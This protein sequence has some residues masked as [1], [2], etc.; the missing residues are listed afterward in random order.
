MKIFAHLFVGRYRYVEAFSLVKI[1]KKVWNLS[2]HLNTKQ[3]KIPPSCLV[4]CTL[5][6]L[7]GEQAI[8]E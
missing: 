3:G 1:K 5:E 8:K 6:Q 4:T 7:S 2:S